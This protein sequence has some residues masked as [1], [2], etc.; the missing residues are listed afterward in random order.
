M[1]LVP[2]AA[3]GGLA[4]GGC[5]A[6]MAASAAGMAAQ[7]ARG[8][9]QSNDHLK[10]AARAECEAHAARY[11]SV[12]IIDVEQRSTSKIVV[13]GTVGEGEQR[14]SFEC[15]YGTKVTGFKLRAI[16]PGR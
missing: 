10:P 16:T 6:A 14:R 7:G 1:L 15:A 2:L 5:V 13:W 4:L 9:P 3:A 11:G 8:R 12:R